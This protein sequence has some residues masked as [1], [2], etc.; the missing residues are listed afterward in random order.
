V[1][2]RYSVGFTVEIPA[3]DLS[4][5]VERALRLFRPRVR[6]GMRVSANYLGAWR[7]SFVMAAIREQR[8]APADRVNLGKRRRKLRRKGAA[9]R[10]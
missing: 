4:Q 3:R 10:T 1:R 2:L 5:A 6:D 8:P 7:G 9:L